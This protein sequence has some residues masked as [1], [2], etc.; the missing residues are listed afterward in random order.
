MALLNAHSFE[1]AETCPRPRADGCRESTKERIMDCMTP[2]RGEE[3]KDPYIQF[4]LRHERARHS[5]LQR[6]T[7]ELSLTQMR[8]CT[9]C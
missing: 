8:A 3:W 1:A 2:L 6:Y 4:I 5:R 9:K 7:L